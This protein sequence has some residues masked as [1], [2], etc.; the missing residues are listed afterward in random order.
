MLLVASAGFVGIADAATWSVEPDGSGDAP[1]IQ[2]A[3]D[4]AAA[5][6]EI[7]LS[8]GVFTG[9]GNRD[10]EGR[11]KSLTIR[12]DGAAPSDCVID[13]EASTGAERRGFYFH[14]GEGPGTVLENL[15]V[16]NGIAPSTQPNEWGGGILC[17]DSSPTIRNCRFVANQAGW[18]GGMLFWNSES[19]VSD[20]WVA[21]NHAYTNG[22]GIYCTT[23]AAPTLR[24]MTLVGNV[25]DG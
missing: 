14:E 12:G 10:I 2:A 3:I 9:P 8:T 25:I 21:D 5:G 19:E 18:G 1:T 24:G 11:G 22:G 4:A 17:V 15:T 7:L 13:C 6:D 23:G 20:C 16:R